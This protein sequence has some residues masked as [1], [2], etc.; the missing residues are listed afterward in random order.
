M[1]ARLNLPEGAHEAT[2][3][4]WGWGVCTQTFSPHTVDEIMVHPISTSHTW[5]QLHSRTPHREAFIWQGLITVFVSCCLY[6]GWMCNWEQFCVCT[7]WSS[8]ADTHCTAVSHQPASCGG[9]VFRYKHT[10]TKV[11]TR[12]PSWHSNSKLPFILKVTD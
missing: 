12:W 4:S 6:A 8:V 2:G 10:V 7:G 1:H 5:R 3:S 11:V 9:K